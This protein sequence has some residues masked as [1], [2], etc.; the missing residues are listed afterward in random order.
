MADSTEGSGE[1]AQQE[2]QLCRICLQGA[3]QRDAF[4]APCNCTGSQR[5]VHTSCLR[6]WQWTVISE[7]NSKRA[8]KCGICRGRFNC[9]LLCGES[10]G[11][12]WRECLGGS[13]H[14]GIVGT[15]PAAVLVLLTMAA[16]VL[17]TSPA[18]EV[19]GLGAGTILV[20]TDHIRSGIFKQSVVLLVQHSK[21]GAHGYI[22]NQPSHAQ[23]R[24]AEPMHGDND[25]MAATCDEGVGGPVPN[26]LRAVL[27]ATNTTD[28]ANVSK[29]VD[30]LWELEDHKAAAFGP[31]MLG[32]THCLR[33]HGYSGWSSRQL[34]GEI[35]RGAWRLAAATRDL[36]FGGDR[37]HLWTHLSNA[38][39][40]QS[41]W[42]HFANSSSSLA[43]G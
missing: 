32:A 39:N 4:L 14:L 21:W 42:T 43:V 23:G 37:Q 3:R 38:S 5:L 2:E 18:M 9:G 15:A 12:F 11:L 35:A 24:A 22:L 31:G 19:P 10:G 28:D 27:F 29:I 34:E 40:G 16:T 6:Q 33:L 20:A 25:F 13:R 36:V 26:H 1:E 30:G 41:L 8:F 7:P 17:R